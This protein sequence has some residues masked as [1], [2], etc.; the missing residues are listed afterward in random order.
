M[1]FSMMWRPA[2]S[3]LFCAVTARAGYHLFAARLPD[4]V[5]TLLA[6]LFAALAYLAALIALGGLRDETFAQ[7]TK[8]S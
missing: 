3:A 7:L 8:R 4:T 6:I 2:V 5:S 1:L